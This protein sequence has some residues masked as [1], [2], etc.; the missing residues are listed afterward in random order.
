MLPDNPLMIRQDEQ[1]LQDSTWFQF[2]YGQIERSTF[3]RLFHLSF[4]HKI[5]DVL[6]TSNVILKDFKANIGY[7]SPVRMPWNSDYKGGG[8]LVIFLIDKKF[9]GLDR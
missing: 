3:N 6:L 9:P 2:H 7:F 1:D 4:S 5:V 8:F